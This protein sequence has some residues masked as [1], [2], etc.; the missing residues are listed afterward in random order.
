MWLA[1]MGV[2]GSLAWMGDFLC[3]YMEVNKATTSTHEEFDWDRAF[4]FTA[5]GTFYMGGFA[6]FVYSRAIPWILSRNII[7]KSFSLNFHSNAR[8]DFL[9]R[10]FFGSIVDNTL[11]APLFYLPSYFIFTDIMRGRDSTFIV[12]HFERSYMVT[13][14][15][16]WGLWIPVQTITFS[17]MPIHLRATF[18]NSV[19]LIWN[20]WLDFYT[21][22][23][24][25]P[26]IESSHALVDEE[27]KAVVVDDSTTTT[28]TS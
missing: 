25:V 12:G 6:N 23:S 21:N 26:M 2:G 3:Q 17:V 11:H 7:S 14:L 9:K 18:V 15:T 27:E 19:C 24:K 20:I 8:K 28:T 16:L 1:N 10:G 13:L 5:F 4:A 22:V